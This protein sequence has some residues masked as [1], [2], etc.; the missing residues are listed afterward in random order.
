MG[1]MKSKRK[2]I[3]EQEIDQRVIDRTDDES[4]WEASISVRKSTSRR[5]RKLI[6]RRLKAESSVSD[7]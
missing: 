4:A 7:A 3:S 2:I 1:Y 5:R 6:E